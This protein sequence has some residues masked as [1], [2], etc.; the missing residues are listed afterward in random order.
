MYL[1]HIAEE[2]NRRIFRLKGPISI[3]YSRSVLPQVNLRA[4]KTP[5][6][7][8]RPRGYVLSLLRKPTD[9]R[10]DAI[11]EALVTNLL[12]RGWDLTTLWAEAI[13]TPTDIDFKFLF[14]KDTNYFSN[15]AVKY[16]PGVAIYVPYNNLDHFSVG[17]FWLCKKY[18]AGMKIANKKSKLLFSYIVPN[19]SI[20]KTPYLPDFFSQRIDTIHK[21]KEQH[22]KLIAEQLNNKAAPIDYRIGYVSPHDRRT[23]RYYSTFYAQ[24]FTN[25]IARA[26]T[27]GSMAAHN[28]GHRRDILERY[29]ASYSRIH[30][31]DRK[32]ATPT[33]S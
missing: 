30:H 18:W 21:N 25:K 19:S 24:L 5:M 3:C 27:F 7:C 17:N 1:S 29:A 28:F 9:V 13:T 15:S 12:H 22:A 10:V 33:S 26:L 20:H 16:S 11:F 14:P 31:V 2:L 8:I 6:P 32:N 23:H 4:K